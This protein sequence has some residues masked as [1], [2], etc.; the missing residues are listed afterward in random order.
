MLVRKRYIRSV[1]NDLISAYKLAPPIDVER[2]AKEL[3]IEVVYEPTDE[4]LSGFLLRDSKNDTAVI[5]VNKNHP[6]TRR[7]FTIAHEL[8]HFILHNYEG[9]HFD[10]DKQSFQ[11]REREPVTLKKRDAVSSQ[12][13]DFE[14]REANYFAAELLMP[15]SFVRTEVKNVGTID[16]FD[17]TE[18][19]LKPMAK[20]FAV[21]TQALI[22]RL[23]NLGYID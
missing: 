7:R 20:K 22:Y 3:G 11:I 17:E 4:G 2:L 19:I 6:V 1:V 13:S 12:G 10:D 5:G 23:T 16:L 9:F 8:G 18:K 21:S 14:E 15:D